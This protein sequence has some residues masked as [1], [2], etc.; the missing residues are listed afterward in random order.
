MSELSMETLAARLEQLE[1]E[2]RWWKVAMALL[3]FLFL[4]GAVWG[5]KPKVVEEIRAKRFLVVGVNDEIIGRLGPE[6]LTL[7]ETAAN[8]I[9]TNRRR[10]DAVGLPPV[11]PYIKLAG[12]TGL[13]ELHLGTLPYQDHPEFGPSISIRDKKAKILWAVP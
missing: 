2:N 4:T 12:P 8:I 10:A 1:R 11:L 5:N 7:D 3:V 13:I 9:L 6:G